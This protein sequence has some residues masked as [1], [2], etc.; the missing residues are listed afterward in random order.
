MAY[1]VLFQ[2]LCSSETIQCF[3]GTFYLHPNVKEYA[4]EETRGRNNGL[5][6]CFEIDNINPHISC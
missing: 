2:L 3:R 5:I 4:K 1:Q 6:L